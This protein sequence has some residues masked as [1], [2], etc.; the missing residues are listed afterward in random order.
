[1]RDAGATRESAPALADAIARAAARSPRR[2]RLRVH[3]VRV[4]APALAASSEEKRG[5]TAGQSGLVSGAPPAPL[6]AYRS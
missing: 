5:A 3:T 1:M 2:K 4:T 6:H